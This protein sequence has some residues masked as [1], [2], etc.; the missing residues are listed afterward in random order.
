MSIDVQINDFKMSQFDQLV[1]LFGSYFQ[2]GDKLLTANYT[3]WLYAKNPFGRARIVTAVESDRWVGFMALIPVALVRRDAQLITY[4]VVNVLVHPEYQGKHIF[5]RMITAAK[6]LVTSENA[7]L[8]GHPNDMALI[9]WKRARMH[10]QDTLMPCLLIPRLRAR[11]V[12]AHELGDLTQ[13]QSVLSIL[14]AQAQQAERWNLLVTE[15]YLRWRYLEHPANIYR[16][17]LIEVSSVPVG[18]QIS[19]KMRPCIS[20]LLDQFMLDRYA[21]DGLACLPWFTVSFRSKSSMQEFSGSVW[22]LPVKKQMP[23]FFTYYQ[24]PCTVGDVMN[25]G[26]SAS[27]F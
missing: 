27:D 1:V 24:K 10:F 13:L 9:M 20:L 25:L 8:M 15:E 12:R 14:H 22:P 11:G 2:P 21:A 16:I 19:R 7:V 4:Y 5:N 6:E 17:Q 23:F 26:L 18:I 3:D